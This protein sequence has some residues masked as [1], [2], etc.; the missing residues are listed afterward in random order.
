MTDNHSIEF[1]SVSAGYGDRKILHS[2]TCK[3]CENRT[4]AIVGPGGSGKSTLLKLLGRSN[5][6][7]GDDLWVRGH[8]RGRYDEVG[9][10][11]QKVEA[12]HQSL[13]DLLGRWPQCG[14]EPERWVREFWRPAAPEAGASLA[15]VI[16][17]PLI[18]L[19]SALRRLAEF[20]VAIG[21]PA[22]ILLIDEPDCGT[23]DRER[24]WV[25]SKLA[26][27][28]G[29]TT[30]V[31]VTHHLGLARSVSD[32]AIFILD[33][34]IVEAGESSQLFHSPRHPRT[35]NLLVYGS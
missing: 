34:H 8:L 5:R 13:T 27:L 22:A 6:P 25:Q 3:I 17:T 26:S 24:E 31:L 7:D 10:L 28:R 2:I 9:V 18:A 1:R 30:I 21:N 23:G 20:T 19:S 12:S 35:R 16:D 11:P 33:G 29:Q 15:S 32:D 14:S 4:T